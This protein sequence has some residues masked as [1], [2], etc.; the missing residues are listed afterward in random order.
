MHLTDN[1]GRTDDHGPPGLPGGIAREKWDYLL[2][3]LSKYDNDIVGS[4]EICPCVPD[5][6]V[7]QASEFI[8][9]VLNW[10]DRPNGQQKPA[11]GAI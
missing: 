10:P 1:F 6:L 9:D 4:F 3:V 2:N 7:R 8:F 5:V 11:D